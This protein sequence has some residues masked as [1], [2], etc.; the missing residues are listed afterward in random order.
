MKKPIFAVFICTLFFTRCNIEEQKPGISTVKNISANF[1]VS[2]KFKDNVDHIIIK[3]SEENY[4]RPLYDYILS[5]EPSKR[6]LLNTK[7]PHENDVIYTFSE[8]QSYIVK[9]INTTAENITLSADGW[10]D[11]I[12]LSDVATE[13]S[14][15]TWLIYTDKPDFKAASSSG[16]P[17]KA[18]YIFDGDIFKI[19]ISWGD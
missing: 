13:Q 18:S 6:V 10:M 8:R 1:D 19:I 11:N 7:Y 16:Y 15:S 2:F 3:E 9:V 4:N 14:D 17:A 5:Y 12:D